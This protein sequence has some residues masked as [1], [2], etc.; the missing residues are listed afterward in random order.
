MLNIISLYF[1]S[2]DLVEICFVL[3]ILHACGQLWYICLIYRV[4]AA[5]HL[6]FGGKSKNSYVDSLNN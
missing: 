2:L 4:E 5:E 6:C 1:F 3:E